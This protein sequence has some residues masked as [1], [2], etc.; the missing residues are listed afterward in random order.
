[1]KWTKNA[2]RPLATEM[3]TTIKQ[4]RLSLPE[5]KDLTARVIVGKSIWNTL[6]TDQRRFAGRFVSICVRRGL[7]G[8]EQ[9]RRDSSNHWRYRPI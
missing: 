9:I 1:M 4:G 8:L 7:L 3:Y 2:C 6:D 5:G